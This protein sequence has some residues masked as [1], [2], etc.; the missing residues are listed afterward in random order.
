VPNVHN[1]ER[2]V[3]PGALPATFNFQPA[4]ILANKSPLHEERASAKSKAF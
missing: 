4:T 2:V 1:P 3:S